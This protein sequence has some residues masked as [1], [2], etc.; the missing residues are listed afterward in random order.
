MPLNRI[1]IL[2]S[3]LV[4]SFISLSN[5]HAN[6]GVDGSPFE[7]TY[8]GIAS[9]KST[10][11]ASATQLLV[12]T[13]DVPSAFDSISRMASKNGYGGGIFAG[14]GLS[15]GSFYTSAEAGFIIDKGNTVFSDGTNT[16]KLSQSNTFE[17]SVRGGFHL[18][19]NALIY[20]LVGYSGTNLKSDGINNRHNDKKGL[21]C[22]VK[23]A[24]T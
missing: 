16:I 17:I 10:F 19:N 1:K 9:I 11:A 6:A 4:I 13:S 2:I 23:R 20:G 15:Y 21:D 3:L 5:I 8:V 18:S 24:W 7:G 12:D 14:Y 22:T